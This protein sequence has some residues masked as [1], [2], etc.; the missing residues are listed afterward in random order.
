MAG[1]GCI[2][3]PGTLNGLD[4]QRL[5][6]P[7]EVVGMALRRAKLTAVMEMV[8]PLYGDGLTA[9][10]ASPLEVLE[11]NLQAIQALNC[12]HAHWHIV[13]A[14]PMVSSEYQDLERLLTPQMAAAVV[15]AQAHRF[16]FGFEHNSADVPLFHRPEVCA[17]LLT[18]VPGLGFVWDFNH[19]AEADFEAYAALASRVSLL[20]VSDTLWPEVNYHL[21]LDQG[22]LDFA[23]FLQ[24]LLAA[25]FAGAA[26]LEIGGLPKSGGYGRDTN[27]ALIGSHLSF[28][29]Q[30][31][32][33]PSR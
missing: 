33:H 1:F 25:N 26:I 31:L 19:T 12:A 20:H 7:L 6:D 14:E 4:G 8:I 32:H 15:L 13:A 18:A 11:A 16:R 21:P 5:G 9:E 10:G 24:P 3:F 23:R 29:E 17:A 28:S 2:Q 27:E 30:I 22:N